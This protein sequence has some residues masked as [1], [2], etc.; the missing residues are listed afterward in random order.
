MHNWPA[1]CTA[2]LIRTAAG[3]VFV[4][5]Q[6]SVVV[7]RQQPVTVFLITGPTIGQSWQQTHVHKPWQRPELEGS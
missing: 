1:A 7:K 4:L 6:Q 3:A 2:G 5:S